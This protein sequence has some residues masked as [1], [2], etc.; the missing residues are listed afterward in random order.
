MQPWRWYWGLLMFLLLLW[1]LLLLHLLWLSGLSSPRSP[2]NDPI[3]RKLILINFLMSSP[4]TSSNGSSTS[5]PARST[6]IKCVVPDHSWY[7]FEIEDSS[8]CGSFSCQV[9]FELQRYSVSWP[10]YAV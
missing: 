3:K 6:V 5:A 1:S 4:A 2:T 7:P 8:W 10:C 9:A